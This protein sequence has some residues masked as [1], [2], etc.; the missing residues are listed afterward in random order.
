M[1]DTRTDGEWRAAIGLLMEDLARRD[2]AERTRRAYRVDLEQ[3]A[4]WAGRAGLDAGRGRPEGGAP[5]HLPPLRARRRPEHERAQARGAACA[6]SEPARARQ[7]RGEPG[8]PRLDASA[9][10]APAARAQRARSGRT[11]RRDPRG[12][13]AGAARPGDVRAR[14]RLRPARG[15]ARHRCARS[16]STTTASSCA[17]RAR[18][19]RRASCPSAS[20]RSRRCVRT[21]N[22]ATAVR[23]VRH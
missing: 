13:A 1:E 12:R 17:W 21:S 19:E 20:P 16:T 23:G 6:V 5:L 18:G 3:F 8:R 7:D 2:A 4:Q 9:R 15:G 10:Y 11:A 14:L 22:Q